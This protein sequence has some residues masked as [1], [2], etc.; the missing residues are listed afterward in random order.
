MGHLYFVFSLSH[1]YQNLVKDKKT[2]STVI[3][4]APEDRVNEIARMLAGQVITD[5]AR[6]AARSLL[7][8]K[9]ELPR[10]ISKDSLS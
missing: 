9:K 5:E 6:E 4:L 8:M 3:K 1:I 2:F 7:K 10:A